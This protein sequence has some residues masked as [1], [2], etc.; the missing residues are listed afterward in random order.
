[1]G[2]NSSV[3][4][5]HRTRSAKKRLKTIDIIIDEQDWISNVIFPVD[6]IVSVKIGFEEAEL[7]KQMKQS[8]AY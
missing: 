6:K 4:A 5:I 8:G 7:R 2:T 3:C 1:M